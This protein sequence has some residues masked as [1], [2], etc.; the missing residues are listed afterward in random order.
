TATPGILTTLT[1]VSSWRTASRGGSRHPLGARAAVSTPP[2]RW[3][4]P[5]GSSLFCRSFTLRATRV[6]RVAPFLLLR[7]PRIHLDPDGLTLPITGGRSE[8]D[9]RDE[10][11]DQGLSKGRRP[12]CEGRKSSGAH[13][14]GCGTG[15]GCF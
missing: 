4:R 11:Q 2:R 12:P 3:S 15:L 10:G 14:A 1:R 7:S 6:R 5:H 9:V 8:Q 13:G